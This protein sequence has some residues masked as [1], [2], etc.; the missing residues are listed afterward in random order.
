LV[1]TDAPEEGDELERELGF[2]V[3]ERI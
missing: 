1:S 2:E 3:V